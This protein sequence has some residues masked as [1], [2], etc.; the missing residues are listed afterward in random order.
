MDAD[1]LSV[2]AVRFGCAVLLFLVSA[3]LVLALLVTVVAC[4]VQ[5]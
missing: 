3:V 4:L 1:H 2:I 5:A